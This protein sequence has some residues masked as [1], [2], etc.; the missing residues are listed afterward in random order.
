MIDLITTTRGGNRLSAFHRLLRSLELQTDTR[1]SV[2][3]IDQSGS[4]EVNHLCR[5]SVLSIRYES[6]AACSLSR[7]RNTGLRYVTAGL[8]GFPDDD[9]EYTPDAI[10]QVYAAF[11]RY[12][13]WGVVA[14]V[15]DK[16][17]GPASGYQQDGLKPGLRVTLSNVFA[18]ANSNAIF[19]RWDPSLEF[20]ERLGTGTPNACGEESDIVLD[21][22]SRG[23]SFIYEPGIRV[24]HPAAKT[25]HLPL[26]RVGAYGRGFG[27]CVSKAVRVRR[28]WPT[29]IPLAVLIIRSCGGVLLSRSA[30]LRRRYWAR[31]N[32]LVTG[33]IRPW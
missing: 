12:D 25:A 22:M 7:A 13:C 6:A 29:L 10:H 3:V 16:K 1:F 28:Q 30:G 8:V 21:C 18:V 33:F 9:C 19:C 31:L 15:R 23:Y 4:S 14:S 26:D 17:G 27:A 5:A 11:Q 32:G 24:W 20:D 2:T